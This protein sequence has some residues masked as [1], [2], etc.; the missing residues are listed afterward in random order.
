[1]QICG[2]LQSHPRLEEPNWNMGLSVKLM[3]RYAVHTLHQSNHVKYSRH[4]ILIG[5][6]KAIRN[7][8]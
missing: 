8:Y 7:N 5:K 2:G 4:E 3:I 6:A 1:M